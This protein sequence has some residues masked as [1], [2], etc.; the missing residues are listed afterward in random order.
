MLN[1]NLTPTKDSEGGAKKSE[2][3]QADKD[4]GGGNNKETH[5]E[6]RMGNVGNEGIA[7]RSPRVVE[8]IMTAMVTAC[9]FV[10]PTVSGTET[11]IMCLR[12]NYVGDVYLNVTSPS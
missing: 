1:H 12:L 2:N 8:Q 9:T 4:H 6:W 10:G 5:T 3:A 7:L 11:E